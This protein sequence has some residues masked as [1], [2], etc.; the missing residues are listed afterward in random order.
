M[1]VTFHM[2]VQ[3]VPCIW[4]EVQLD[5]LKFLDPLL[6]RLAVRCNFL[7]EAGS[8][9]QAEYIVTD[10]LNTDKGKWYMIFLLHCVIMLYFF[11]ESSLHEKH[12]VTFF[13]S[14]LRTQCYGTRNK[15]TAHCRICLRAFMSWFPQLEFL[16]S[17]CLSCLI[18]QIFLLLLGNY[19]VLLVSCLCVSHT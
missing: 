17:V 16:D 1:D 7:E 3:T 14:V 12:F 4:K 9:L 13:F 2:L 15:V 19:I 5:L 18:N 10:C 6:Q 8:C 11:S